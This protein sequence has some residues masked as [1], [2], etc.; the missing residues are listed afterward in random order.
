[1]A[2]G[3]FRAAHCTVFCCG[4]VLVFWDRHE[5]LQGSYCYTPCCR[6]EQGWR[7]ECAELILVAKEGGLGENDDG[8]DGNVVLPVLQ[9]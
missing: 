8:L 9:V 4:E 7:V 1:M 2:E 5:W 6:I 3:W